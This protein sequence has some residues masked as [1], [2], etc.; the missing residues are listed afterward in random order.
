MLTAYCADV[1]YIDD[2]IAIEG[3]TWFGR[4]KDMGD[5]WIWTNATLS[6]QR[7][8]EGGPGTR[9]ANTPGGGHGVQLS[10]G[11]LV[12]PK[13]AGT[14][15]GVSICYSDDHGDTWHASPTFYGELSW[16]EVE[17]AELTRK[18]GA[19]GKTPVLYM[20][21]RNDEFGASYPQGGRQMSTSTDGG[22]TWSPQENVQVPDPNCKGGIVQW[23]ASVQ[24]KC[25]PARQRA[26]ASGGCKHPSSR[27]R[28][29]SPMHTLTEDDGIL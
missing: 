24:Q 18:G 1:R 7:Q 2:V 26:R 11:R 25:P 21:I 19:D 20:T 15:F 27:S 10:T 3:Q 8:G 13:Y 14:P 9:S 22:L 6:C 12:I 28:T 16:T 5:T 23:K 4:S 29:P 17:I